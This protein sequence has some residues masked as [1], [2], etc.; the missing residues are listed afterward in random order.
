M[1]ILNRS[2]RVGGAQPPPPPP[3]PDPGV[4]PPGGFTLCKDKTGGP[5]TI[6]FPP[7]IDLNGWEPFPGASG[8]ARDALPNFQRLYAGLATTGDLAIFSQT[9][10]SQVDNDQ[11]THIGVGDD[12][13]WYG[14]EIKGPAINTLP[15]DDP[16]W[17]GGVGMVQSGG[18]RFLCERLNVHDVGD[19]I[20]ISQGWNAEPWNT[21]KMSRFTGLS[22]DWCVRDG[23]F[24]YIHDDLLENDHINGGSFHDCL[25]EA[26]CMFSTR[27]GNTEVAAEGTNGSDQ[28]CLV[29]DSALW[30]R[31]QAQN[32][33]DEAVAQGNYLTSFHKTITQDAYEFKNLTYL[34]VN[35]IYRWDGETSL[36]QYGFWGNLPDSNIS[37]DSHGNILCAV[38]GVPA[39]FHV[40]KSWTVV[41]GAT[42]KSVWSNRVTRH[43]ADHPYFTYLD[44]NNNLRWPGFF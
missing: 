14:G 11:V 3:P 1:P 18:K 23:L 42:S 10:A 34:F 35:T 15:W 6:I 38:N 26:H 20:R 32:H 33:E 24:Q 5:A 21:D 37:D 2:V 30:L 25:G 28:I 36:S 40:P 22:A 19:A 43:M 17:H 7:G 4:P 9:S 41:T 29:N 31:G 16:G 13:C 27:V 39:G 44:R 12:I 8:A